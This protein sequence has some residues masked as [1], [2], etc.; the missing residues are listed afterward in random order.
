MMYV[1]KQDIK[2]DKNQTGSLLYQF[3]TLVYK[4]YVEPSRPA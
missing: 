1:P 2:E 4:L 3:F